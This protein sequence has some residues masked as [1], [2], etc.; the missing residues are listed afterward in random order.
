MRCGERSLVGKAVPLWRLLPALGSCFHM[1]GSALHC[2]LARIAVNLPPP[3]FPFPPAYYARSQS[4][5]PCSLPSRYV[6]AACKS[7]ARRTLDN[8]S[9]LYASSSHHALAMFSIKY[10]YIRTFSRGIEIPLGVTGDKSTR[11]L[12]VGARADRVVQPLLGALYALSK[13]L[14]AGLRSI[15]KGLYSPQWP[16][17]PSS[18]RHKRLVYLVRR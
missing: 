11:S 18:R 5:K 2:P 12:P 14:K 10:G 9:T 13:W 1:V 15:Y 4:S 16:T 6:C 3:S 8:S 17:P 7:R